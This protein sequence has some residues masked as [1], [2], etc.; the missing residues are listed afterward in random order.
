[1]GRKTNA[2]SMALRLQLFGETCD[3]EWHLIRWRDKRL[4]KGND[5]CGALVGTCIIV[6][7][8]KPED[9]IWAWRERE[10]ERERNYKS[11]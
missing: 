4:P 3:Q 6:R 10:R 8:S 1:M 5:F 7:V 11:F 9:A 2:I